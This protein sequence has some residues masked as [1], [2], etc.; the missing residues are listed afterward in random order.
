LAKPV[1]QLTLLAVLINDTMQVIST[2]RK[3][4]ITTLA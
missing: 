2:D 3:K 1:L 4:G